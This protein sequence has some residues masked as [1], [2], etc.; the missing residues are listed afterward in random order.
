MKK[1]KKE[2]KKVK[3]NKVEEVQ[4]EWGRYWSDDEGIYDSHKDNMKGW[5][6]EETNALFV[7]EDELRR[8]WAEALHAWDNILPG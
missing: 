6:L 5:P 4:D 2:E 7:G 8:R 3:R 1:K